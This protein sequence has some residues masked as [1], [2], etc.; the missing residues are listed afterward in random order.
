MKDCKNCAEKEALSQ[1]AIGK[2]NECAKLRAELAK[3]KD[4]ITDAV[5]K[6]KGRD[7]AEKAEAMQNELC[8]LAADNAAMT[9]ELNELRGVNSML[10]KV[11]SEKDELIDTLRK[12]NAALEKE[13][14]DLKKRL[15][16]NS[17]HRQRCRAL[18]DADR[19]LANEIREKDHELAQK[20]A[21]IRELEGIL[22]Y[23]P[24]REPEEKQADGLVDAASRFFE[25][26]FSYAD[27]NEDGADA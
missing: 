5:C 10:R 19:W 9:G 21:K 14:D 1:F 16:D 6:N 8:R 23:K 3:A 25:A 15:S 27:G 11:S 7:R 20:D 24:I 4:A 17:W 18:E 26:L 2:A 12:K 22:C 13:N